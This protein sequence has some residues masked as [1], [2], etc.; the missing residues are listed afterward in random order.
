MDRTININI[1]ISIKDVDRNFLE[2]IATLASALGYPAT[3]GNKVQ[4]TV[5][6]E[7][8]DTPVKPP[9]VEVTDVPKIEMKPASEIDFDE[10][11]KLA[12]KVSEVCGKNAVA[13][14]IKGFKLEDGKTQVPKIT[15]LQ[16]KD[17]K[18]FMEKLNAELSVV[19]QGEMKL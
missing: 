10:V 15:Q 12:Y 18:A 13:K 4:E 11:K 1:N 9:V 3:V 17:Y 14:A 16:Q 7:L 5:K 6:E 2:T 19:S 8:K